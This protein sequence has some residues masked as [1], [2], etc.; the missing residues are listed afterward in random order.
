MAEGPQLLEKF[1]KELARR[2]MS[3]AF[4][5]EGPLTELDLWSIEY[6]FPNELVGE[7]DVDLDKA[8]NYG[9]ILRRKTAQLALT[10]SSIR[11]LPEG[12]IALPVKFWKL[13][14]VKKKL[15]RTSRYIRTL[16]VKE[17]M[18]VRDFCGHLSIPQP[19]TFIDDE[20][21]TTTELLALNAGELQRR[22]LALSFES[23]DADE[24]VGLD[25]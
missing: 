13:S 15:R 25:W 10:T 3:A 17:R 24:H 22:N 16:L 8:A 12:L 1:V 18:T 9:L 2:E 5:A 4:R 14:R 11:V 21:A 7:D 23:I 6:R 19:Q 20:P